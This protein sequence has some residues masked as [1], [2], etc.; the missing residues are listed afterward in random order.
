MFA[1]LRALGDGARGRTLT[2]LEGDLGLAVRTVRRAFRELEECGLLVCDRDSRHSKRVF[3]VTTHMSVSAAQNG[4]KRPKTAHAKTSQNGPKRPNAA[5][6]L[7]LSVNTKRTEAVAVE[8]PRAPARETQPPAFGAQQQR[9]QLLALEGSADD[10]DRRAVYAVLEQ[11]DAAVRRVWQRIGQTHGFLAV[12]EASVAG[13]AVA[14][15]RY[16]L[17]E[18]EAC[19]V[20]SAERVADGRLSAGYFATTFRGNGFCARH[21]DWQAALRADERRRREESA[22][23][24]DI[25]THRAP[26]QLELS[27]EELVARSADVLRMFSQGASP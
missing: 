1:H 15:R 19:V 5:P 22:I 16:P 11:L 18:L 4:P 3:S 6:P 23:A 14:M 9:Q 20:W 21:R 25:A 17:A 10:R 27:G 24:A 2:E 26:A 13:L 12:D 7:S 8:P